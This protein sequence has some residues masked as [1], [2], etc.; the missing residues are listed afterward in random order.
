MAWWHWLVAGILLLVLELVTPG[1]LF[2]IFFGVAAVIVGI[3]S[4]VSLSGPLWMQIVLFAVLSLVAL[5]TLRG[6]LLARLH[7]RLLTRDIDSIAG[8]TAI[9]LEDVAMGGVGK[10][11]LRGAA[12]SARNVGLS[13]IANG[14]RCTVVKVEG[15]TLWVSEE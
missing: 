5:F 7:S 8:E 4:A 3:L 15:L 6:M 1:A 11:E 9:M 12:W 13:P 10:A 2:L 14:Q